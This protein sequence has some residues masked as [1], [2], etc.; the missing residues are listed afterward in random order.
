MMRKYQ[1]DQEIRDAVNFNETHDTQQVD[2]PD[3]L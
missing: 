1:R 2:V 3:P